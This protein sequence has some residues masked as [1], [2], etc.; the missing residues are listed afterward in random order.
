MVYC[1]D[2]SRHGS[3]DGWEAETTSWDWHLLTCKSTLQNTQV[4]IN[5]SVHTVPTPS[6]LCDEPWF[7]SMD[8][9]WTQQIHVFKL[10]HLSKLESAVPVLQSAWELE[11]SKPWQ[12]CDHASDPSPRQLIQALSEMQHWSPLQG[13]LWSFFEC[14]SWPHQHATVRSRRK[15]RVLLKHNPTSLLCTPVVV[16][17][18]RMSNLMTFMTLTTTSAQNDPGAIVQRGQRYL[19][20][21]HWGVSHARESHFCFDHFISDVQFKAILVTLQKKL[22]APLITR[23][24]QQRSL[25]NS[26]KIYSKNKKIKAHVQR[27]I[28]LFFSCFFWVLVLSCGWEASSKAALCSWLLPT[29]PFPVKDGFSLV[30]WSAAVTSSNHCLSASLRV[31]GKALTSRRMT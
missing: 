22:R 15:G 27:Q 21:L 14:R 24:K 29:P 17:M 23:T 7:S 11:F 26:T 10:G 5:I 9:R 20:T 18:L 16:F 1:Q 4:T 30:Y 2:H 8:G 6:G 28:R 25:S 3:T 19:L 13:T 12:S 31:S